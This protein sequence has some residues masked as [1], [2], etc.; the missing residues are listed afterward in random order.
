MARAT[1]DFIQLHG[2]LALRGNFNKS[3][4]EKQVWE[5]KKKWKKI[6]ETKYKREI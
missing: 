4:C 3:V 5:E 6:Q 1:E 2:M